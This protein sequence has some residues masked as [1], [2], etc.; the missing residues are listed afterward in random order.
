MNTRI[1]GRYQLV[2]EIG[3][4]GMGRVYQA[5]DT[6]TGR[7]VAAKIM[8]ATAESDIQALLRFQQE[9]AVL[10]TLK[11]PNIVQVSGTFL[12]EETCSIVMELLEGRSLAD[13]LHTER[14]SLPRI[15]HLSEQ[16]ATALVYA[17][18]R[19]IVH[20][21]IKPDNVMVVGDDRVK[22]T[23]FGIARILG[24]GAPHT[25]TG[26]SLGTPLYMAPEQIRGQTVDGRTDIYALG[27]VMYQMVTGQPPFEGSDPLSIAFK[28]VH[29]APEP[30]TRVSA[31][32]PLDWEG[33]ILTCLAKAPADRF[34]TAAQLEAA[35]SRLS[36][37]YGTAPREYP[38]T[39]PAIAPPPVREPAR[40]PVIED[41]TT[42]RPL[43]EP[44]MPRQVP[45]SMV[46]MAASHG[47]SSV[48]AAPKV[49][50]R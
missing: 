7:A 46:P 13:I 39:P 14:L 18:G 12:E 48:T 28:H 24:G 38:V 50:A 27:A 19:G 44:A 33:L 29:E 16:V 8:T 4:G 31:D 5:V 35:I 25:L 10:S 47:P 3:R 15:K 17:H 36:T 22:V 1:G 42:H 49:Q 21:D 30:P 41:R 9:G 20:R 23:D 2:R 11:H 32:V 37:G 26:M 45:P 40:P 34:Q 6:E 43:A